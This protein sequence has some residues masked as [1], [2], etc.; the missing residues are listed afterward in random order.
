MPIHKMKT[1]KFTAPSFT[2]WKEAAVTTLK[3]K[4]FESLNTKTP[5]GI[6]LKPLYTKEDTDQLEISR[7]TKPAFGWTI[8][9]PV[10][11]ANGE[12]YVQQMKESLDRGNQAIAY[13]GLKPLVWAEQDLKQ[14]A[15]LMTQYPILFT[16]VQ[17]NDPI[18]RAFTYVEESKRAEVQGIC[19][20]EVPVLPEGFD[21]VRAKGAD[22]W[23]AHH[24]GADAVTELALSL[25]IAAERAEEAASFEEFT[26][27]FYVR[28]ASDTHFFMEIAKFR[29]FRVL[30]KLFNEAYGVDHPQQVP[31]LGI[32]SLRSYSKL[33]PYVNLLRGGNSAFAAVLG[34][35]D[36]LTVLPHDVLT[37]T[38]QSSNRYARNIQLILKEETHIDQ[39]LDPAGGSYFIESLTSELIR[40]AWKKFLEIEEMGGSQAFLQSG[41]LSKLYAQRQKELATGKKTLI[42]TNVYAELTD[43]SFED[44]A[45]VS[46]SKRLAEPFENLRS[47]QQGELPKTVLL[48]FGALKD[49]K[50]RADFVSGF[51][52]VGG[53]EAVWSPSF[54]S[55]DQ[56]LDW[57]KE[58]Q[59]D[60]AVICASSADAEEAVTNFLASYKGN[61]VID[62]AGKYAQETADHWQANGLNGFIFAGQDK[63]EKLN[64]IISNTKGGRSVE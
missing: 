58:Q 12:Q 22:L 21:G 38:S 47:K 52:A 35:A 63:I 62:A 17:S 28:F 64:D 54:E 4:P 1:F 11:A 24:E 49:Y 2:E 10:S 42:G 8:A 36:W 43:L 59:P 53:I 18:L 56:A 33:D 45:T 25:A 48:N 6:E 30:W 46:V 34:G 51:L 16:E 5:E 57:I 50:P 39:V 19:I 32:T 27:S 13:N 37:G 29:A 23:T 26:K 61:C 9:Q 15:E 55:N 31:L 7:V 60:Y 44:A 14:V 41:E 3:G 20:S 40:K